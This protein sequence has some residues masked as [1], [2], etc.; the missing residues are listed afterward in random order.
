MLDPAQNQ[1]GRAA[2]A[3][4][5]AFNAQHAQG[6]DLNGTMGGAFFNVGAPQVQISSANQ[7]TGTVGASISDVGALTTK[8]YVL[9]Y[10]GSAWSLRDTAGNAVAMTGTGTALPSAGAAP[11]LG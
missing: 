2:V 1:L 8:D 3:M 4:A 9:R 11:P 6:M 7:G 10:D 5:S